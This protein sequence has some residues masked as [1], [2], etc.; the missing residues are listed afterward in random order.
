ME[1]NLRATKIVDQLTERAS[2]LKIHVERSACGTQVVDC[3]VV[4]VGGLEAGIALARVCLADLGQVQIIFDDP[5][6]FSG[7]AV[8]VCSDHP[9]AACMASQY[10]GWQLTGKNYFAMGSG[11]FRAAAGRESLFETIGYQ[12]DA[13]DVVGVLETGSLPPDELCVDLAAACRVA[14]DHLKLLVARTSS[15]AGSVQV[16]ARSIETALHKMFELGYDLSQVVSAV[17]LSPLP[18]VAVDDLAGIG[19]TNDAVLYGGRVTLWVRGDDQWI[20]T[21]GP[22]IPSCSSKDFGQPFASIFDAYERDFYQI[23]PLL[24]SPASITL[25]N[26]DTGNSHAFGEVR[27]DI[28]KR[29]FECASPS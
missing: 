2:V 20:A 6:Y 16:V 17:G 5:Q 9:V 13:K 10:A 12:E 4:A 27:P 7:P 28:L 3:G 1:L 18:P 29:S 23:D 22:R 24:F 15:L 26:I 21:N 14:P 11:P 8:M 25:V 19:R